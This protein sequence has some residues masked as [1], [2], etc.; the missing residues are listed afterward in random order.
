VVFP[1]LIFNE[2]VYNVLIIGIWVILG[3]NLFKGIFRVSFGEEIDYLIRRNYNLFLFFRVLAW[4]FITFFLL[5]SIINFL[6]NFF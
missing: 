2:V 3:L 5:L 6:K 1:T 4:G